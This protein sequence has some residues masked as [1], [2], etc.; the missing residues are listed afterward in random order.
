[1]ELIINIV[2]I[3]TNRN[4]IIGLNFLDDILCNLLLHNLVFVRFRY[5]IKVYLGIPLNKLGNKIPK[6]KKHF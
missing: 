5:V 4:K 6:A 3:N 2:H 1:M